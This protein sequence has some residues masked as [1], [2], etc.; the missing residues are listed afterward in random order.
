M[1]PVSPQVR[2]CRME[3]AHL[4]SRRHLDLLRLQIEGR[5]EPIII[6]QKAN[7]ASCSGQAAR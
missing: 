5:A 6:T 1:N 3:A 4:E 2:L 7:A